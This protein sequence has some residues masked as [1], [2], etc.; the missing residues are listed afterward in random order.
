M[1]RKGKKIRK[2]GKKRTVCKLCEGGIRRERGRA[3]GVSG[4]NKAFL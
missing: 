4:K 3:D 2:K 1:R